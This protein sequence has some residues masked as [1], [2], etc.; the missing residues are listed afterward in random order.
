MASENSHYLGLPNTLGRSKTA[1]FGYLKERMQGRIQGRDKKWLSIGGKE[2]LIKAVSQALSSYAMSV[3][4]LP[5]T[6]CKDME[7]LMSKFWWRSNAKKDRGIHWLSWDR[8]CVKKSN[9]GLG[10]RDLR[11]FNIALLGKQGWKFMLHP[12]SLVSIVIKRDIF[13]TDRS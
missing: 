7:Q 9:G 1:M 5:S 3:F 4:L 2:I 11:D 8:M 6:L 13:Q 10:F 12:N